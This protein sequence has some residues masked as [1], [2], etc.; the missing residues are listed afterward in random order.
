MHNLH[1]CLQEIR[2]ILPKKIDRMNWAG[3]RVPLRH[4]HIGVF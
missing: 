3:E 2:R 1:P 4:N